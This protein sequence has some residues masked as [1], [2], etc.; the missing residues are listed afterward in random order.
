MVMVCF[1]MGRPGSSS[2][3]AAQMPDWCED[4]KFRILDSLAFRRCADRLKHRA[5]K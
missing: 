5:E 3:S 2:G 1:Q 4:H